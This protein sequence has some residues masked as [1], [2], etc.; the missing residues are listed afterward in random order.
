M[1]D[2]NNN[3]GGSTTTDADVRSVIENAN[4]EDENSNRD[5]DAD[6][7]DD[8]GSDDDSGNG[9]D[10]DTTDSDDDDSSDDDADDSADDDDSGDSDDNGDADEDAKSKR[11]FKQ[12]AGDGS[13]VSYISNLEK[14]HEASTTE[15]LNTKSELNR[16]QGNLDAIISAA[17]ADPDLAAKLKK[18]TE[19]AGSGD[20]QG[21]GDS[22]A[23]VN[24]FLLDTQTKWTQ[25]SEKEIA[26]FIDANPEVASDPK[27]KADVQH[28]MAVFSKEHFARTKT[29]LSGGEAMDQAY[30]YLGLENKL[31]KQ[32]LGNGAKKF[33]APTRPRS[34]SKKS[35]GQKTSYTPDQIAFAKS[36]GKD[37]AWLEK[38]AAK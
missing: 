19:G 5:E 35:G 29:L 4:A 13:D 26:D 1:A 15:A 22:T 11:R 28:W 30:K 25:K 37:Q 10:S 34:K 36:M 38:N 3:Q 6:E 14:A 31:E 24:P 20:S 21:A 8:S 7:D 9:D 12:Y 32:N 2:R 27:I 33:A 16:V 23:T 18:V 17:A